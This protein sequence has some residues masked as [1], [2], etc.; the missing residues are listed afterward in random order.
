VLVF[1][2]TSGFR[3]DSIAAG[4]A[5]V[6][7]IAQENGFTVVASEDAS[8]FTT[9]NL[10]NYSTIV[11]MNTT[12]DIFTSAQETAFK[13]YIEN[14][15]G[16]VGT[17]SAADTEHDWTWY[18]DTLLG[19]G[20]FIH[21]GDG[22]PRATVNIE[23]PTNNLVSHIG[24]TWVMSDEWYF[25]RD[26]PRNSSSIE[27]LGTLDRS[28][29]TSN[30]PVADHPVIYTN[31]IGTGRAF[32]TAI[33]HV[34]SNFSDPKMEEMIRKAIEWTSNITPVVTSSSSRAASSVRSSSSLAAVSSSRPASSVQASSLQSSSVQV[35]SIASSLTGG[36][37]SSR[38]SISSAASSMIVVASSSQSSARS[39][40]SSVALS[41]VTAINSS[42]SLSS[43]AAMSSSSRQSSTGTISSTAASAQ[44]SANS[45]GGGGGSM[46]IIELLMMAMFSL[47]LGARY[48]P[49]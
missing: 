7:K 27:V 22:I 19:G 30:Y 23:K 34:D 6:Q 5:M 15:G 35:S 14:G 45:D 47:L 41:S 2:K 13:S 1:S 28:S 4:I 38:S 39:S 16:F 37:A 49:D 31:T 24:S 48:R 32:Y 18:T 3:H 20:E 8:L 10:A 40:V 12:G 43:A 46:G 25:W 42:S 26:N 29:Y 17:H 21:H 36:V 11:F 44:S 33:G 9:A